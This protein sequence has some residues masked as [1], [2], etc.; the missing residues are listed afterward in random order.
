[1]MKIGYQGVYVHIPFCK[2]KCLYCDF[3]SYEGLLEA[4]SKEYVN[5]LCCEINSNALFFSQV[6]SIFFGGGTPTLLSCEQFTRIVDALKRKGAW[7]GDEQERTCEANPGTIDVEKLSCLLELGFNRLSLGVQSFSDELLARI[8]RIHSSKQAIDAVKAAQATGWKNISVDL[9]Y[10]LPGQSLEDLQYSLKQAIDLGVQHMSV[11]SL[12]VEEDTLLEKLVLEKKM[13]L[14]LEDVENEMYDW[15]NNF[16]PNNG[17]VR[18][19]VSNYAL[20]GFCSR[21]NIVYWK[22]LPY[23]GFGVAACSFDGMSR[24]SNSLDVKDY[25]YKMVN[26]KSFYE[27]ECID[28]KYL[29]AEYMF[30]GLRMVEGVDVEAFKFRFDEDIFVVY[31]AEID[32]NI[33]DGFLQ[34][35]NTKI[36]LT[37]LGMKMGNKI[38][39][40]FLP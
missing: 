23:K 38:F 12:I 33:Q 39:L 16:L 37:E 5:A 14:P 32:K 24:T 15:V 28:K 8:G 9:M 18:Y 34:L 20:D 13:V 2:S 10:G 40:T 35:K 7:F 25:I 21:H 26:G 27:K 19:E 11:Y 29:M 1:M 4:F 36:M 30:M 3:P 22:Y 17:Y 6:K 31:G